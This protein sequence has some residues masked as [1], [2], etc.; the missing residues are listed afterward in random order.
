MLAAQHQSGACCDASTWLASVTRAV[1]GGGAG[2]GSGS[3]TI[4]RVQ[5]G[6]TT[7]TA[8][9][10]IERAAKRNRDMAAPPCTRLREAR[11][12]SARS[13]RE[14]LGSP[15][16]RRHTALKRRAFRECLS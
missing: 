9:A 7:T 15:R 11:E 13:P 8:A 16:R 1:V 5:P 12:K 2:G 10:T 6:T 4:G 14:A 3:V